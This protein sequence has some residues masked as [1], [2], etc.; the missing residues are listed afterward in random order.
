MAAANA[1]YTNAR[2]YIQ[3]ADHILARTYMVVKDQKLLFAAVENIFLGLE[4]WMAAAITDA[5]RLKRKTKKE[6]STD[7]TTAN[8]E[9]LMRAFKAQAAKKYTVTAKELQF[10]M[11]MHTLIEDHKKSDVEFARKDAYVICKP[12]YDATIVSYDVANMWLAQA[13]KI[14][15]KIELM[16]LK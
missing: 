6:I 4:C 9:K 3:V 7:K 10:I 11:D 15:N 16:K 14:G 8:F 2:E 13:R 12:G 1:L 5:S